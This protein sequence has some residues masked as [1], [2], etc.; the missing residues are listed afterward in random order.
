MNLSASE[1][2]IV[3]ALNTIGLPYERLRFGRTADTY[4]VYS[5]LNHQEREFSDDEAEAEETLYSI[6]LF[7][8]GNH[9]ELI[10]KVK[11]ALKEAGFFDISIEAEIYENDTGYY[12]VPFE[13][14]YLEV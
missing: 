8:K 14:R 5:L 6:D 2:A 4:I 9:V 12:H 7:S 1:R 11:S 13:A 10:R 3:A